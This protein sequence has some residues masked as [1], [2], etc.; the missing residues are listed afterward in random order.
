MKRARP[1][2]EY[3]ADGVRAVFTAPEEKPE[4]KKIP[5]GIPELYH[6]AARTD[7][8]CWGCIY[9]L[10]EQKAASM[11][12]PEISL[13][14]NMYQRNTGHM[15]ESELCRQVSELHRERIYQPLIDEGKAAEA[16]EWHA[17]MVFRHFHTHALPLVNVTVAT[18]RELQ[19]NI[20]TIKELMYERDPETNKLQPVHANIKQYCTLIK[21]QRELLQD[22]TR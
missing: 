10:T 22:V 21:L 14:W 16:L 1:G 4:S 12:I 11:M 13:L 20:D 17:D 5:V 6:T 15:D 7:E 18:I 2:F 8:Q 19:L 3:E 9:D